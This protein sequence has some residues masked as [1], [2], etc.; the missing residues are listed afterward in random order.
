MI[1]AS[2]EAEYKQG[3]CKQEYMVVIAELA[4]QEEVGVNERY[5][6]SDV[7]GKNSKNKKQRCHKEYFLYKL[8]LIKIWDGKPLKSRHGVSE[9]FKMKIL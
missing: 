4:K 1:I 2:A 7:P 8:V 5:K 3:N 9:T 6:Y